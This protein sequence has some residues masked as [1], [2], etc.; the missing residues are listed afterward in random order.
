MCRSPVPL[1]QDLMLEPLWI[2]IFHSFEFGSPWGLVFCL[3][4]PGKLLFKKGSPKGYFSG[5]ILRLCHHCNH[6][7]SKA[8]LYKDSLE[9]KLSCISDSLDNSKKRNHL[10]LYRYFIMGEHGTLGRHIRICIPD[11][12]VSFIHNICAGKCHLWS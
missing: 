7:P 8:I 2:G 5:Q 6:N 1:V 3:R 11:C 9:G 12:V 4:N 10:Y